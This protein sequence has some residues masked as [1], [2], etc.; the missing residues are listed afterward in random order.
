[1]RQW[2]FGLTLPPLWWSGSWARVCGGCESCDR[3][4]TE[5][6]TWRGTYWLP[7]SPSRSH[8]TDEALQRPWRDTS[9][10]LLED[11]RSLL[12]L[13]VCLFVC[14]FFCQKPLCADYM[15]H[16]TVHVTLQ[17]Q[18]CRLSR[19]ISPVPS[20]PPYKTLKHSSLNV[21]DQLDD[22]HPSDHDD[23]QAGLKPKRT[24]V[25]SVVM[26]SFCVCTWIHPKL[27]SNT[28]T[29]RSSSSLF[30]WLFAL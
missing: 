14:L 7:V 22:S 1:M 2:L 25:F 30:I 16:T 28:L 6:I 29:S 9:Q 21:I 20:G 15:L 24:L 11:N 23:V 17:K 19:L 26:E 3:E 13:F 12:F 27:R 4:K 10:T 5:A 18:T 8:V